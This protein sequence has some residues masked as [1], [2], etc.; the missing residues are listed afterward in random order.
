LH[1]E[2]TKTYR[3][4]LKSSVIHQETQYD[5]LVKFPN[6]FNDPRSFC[7]NLLL[8]CNFNFHCFLL[9]KIICSLLKTNSD[10]LEIFMT[11][12]II[13]NS[14][15]YPVPEFSS[16]IYISINETTLHRCSLIH[17]FHLAVSISWPSDF[18]NWNR[19][20]YFWNRDGLDRVY[21]L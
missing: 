16:E 13:T 12:T 8:L 9:T 3:I 11:L 7:I 5:L 10:N 19:S 2:N 20:T 4:N 17:P 6:I 14:L 21:L 18:I 1:L 15:V